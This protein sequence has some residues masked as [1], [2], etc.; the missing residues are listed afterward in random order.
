MGSMKDAAGRNRWIWI[1]V[2]MGLAGAGLMGCGSSADTGMENTGQLSGDAAG[3]EDSGTDAGT[4]SWEEDIAH[5]G[6]TVQ[7]TENEPGLSNGNDTEVTDA[8]DTQTTQTESVK[9][10]I[11]G[12]SLST[13]V[14]WIPGE[15]SDFFP[16][17][18]ALTD[19]S[20]TWW[21]QVLDETG[22]E[23]CANNSS[24]GSTCV[25][26][27][28]AIGE[29]KYGCSGDRL[30]RLTSSQGKIPDIIIVY[31]GTNDMVNGVPIGD[32]D[33]TIPVEEGEI[34]YFSDAYTL[35]LDKLSS[36]YPA[37]KIYCCGLHQLGNWGT[38][39]PFVTFK[40]HLGLTAEDYSKQ[41]ETIA[42]NKGIPYIDLYHCGIEIDNLDE[43]TSD[44]VHF[45][46]LGMKYVK[47]AVLNGLTR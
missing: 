13:Y 10:S 1:M 22:M 37:A 43:M 18:G 32:N 46:P 9:L 41:I 20:E 25:G 4:D 33:G 6:E 44:G 16:M 38:T 39:Q 23:L 3:M 12:D 7:G 35:I 34:D 29:M 8:F 30:S 14:G 21:M 40:N 45:T 36:E 2:C 15:C 17:N 28:L 27:S 11:L 5:A 47:E 19:V 24:S 26:N 42:A 31:M